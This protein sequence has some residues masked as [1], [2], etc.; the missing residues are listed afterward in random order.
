MRTMEQSPN[1]VNGLRTLLVKRE[2][3][4]P[5]PRSPVHRGDAAHHRVFLVP[6]HQVQ[7]GG[8]ENGDRHSGFRQHA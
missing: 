2:Q 8:G 6:P 3:F 7:V 1:G 5:S 4:T